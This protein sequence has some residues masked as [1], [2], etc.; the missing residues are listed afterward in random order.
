MYVNVKHILTINHLLLPCITSCCRSISAT[1]IVQL[2]PK[3]WTHLYALWCKTTSTNSHLS[4]L[5]AQDTRHEWNSAGKTDEATMSDKP[6]GDN[7]NGDNVDGEVP[8][9]PTVH[10]AEVTVTDVTL[11]S[12]TVTFK[13]SR[14]AKGFFRDWGLKIWF[15]DDVWEVWW[16]GWLGCGSRSGQNQRFHSARLHPPNE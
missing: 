2:K 11:N 8:W 16:G 14:M 7:H 10:P 15:R 9:R 5:S 12:L 1:S 6:Q 3:T 13:E 4:S